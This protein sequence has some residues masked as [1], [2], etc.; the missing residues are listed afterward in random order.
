VEITTTQLRIEDNFTEKLK[1]AGIIVQL[2]LSFPFAGV[3][4][5]E[6]KRGSNDSYSIDC[7]S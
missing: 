5:R 4:P 3:N 6:R 1:G 2:T 7:S